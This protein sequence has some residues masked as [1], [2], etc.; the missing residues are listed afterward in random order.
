MNYSNI[1]IKKTTI[2][3]ARRILPFKLFSQNNDIL[4]PHTVVSLLAK[5]IDLNQYP[6]LETY[7][8]TS[9]NGDEVAV[10]GLIIMGIWFIVQEPSQE[11]LTHREMVKVRITDEWF[12]AL[13][14]FKLS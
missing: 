8:R 3:E 9:K 2:E 10:H 7:F 1:W 6:I 14:K 12:N 13:E 11:E 5:N 4:P